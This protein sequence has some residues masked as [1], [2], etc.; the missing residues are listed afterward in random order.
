MRQKEWFSDLEL[1]ML[2]VK[3][4]REGLQ[5]LH[6]EEERAKLFL[7]KRQALHGC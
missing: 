6:L 5:A 7:V 4:T 1:G 3:R 2:L